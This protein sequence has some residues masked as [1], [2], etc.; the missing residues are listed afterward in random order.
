MGRWLGR[1]S[2]L[3]EV[4]EEILK[5]ELLLCPAAEVL[6]AGAVWGGV[7][8]AVYCDVPEGWWTRGSG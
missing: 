8:F 7:C 2:V 5:E 6:W 3:Q 4:V 1:D